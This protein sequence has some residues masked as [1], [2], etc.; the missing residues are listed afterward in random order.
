MTGQQ[1]VTR[2]A[3]IYAIPSTPLY[4][5]VVGGE[6]AFSFART[7]DDVVECVEEL[8]GRLPAADLLLAALHK[9]AVLARDS[10]L[11]DFVEV[12]DEAITVR[13]G[14]I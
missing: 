2:T 14:G 5:L 9:Y 4:K 13:E 11:A 6:P 1:N 12:L 3:E 10:A 7:A 8:N